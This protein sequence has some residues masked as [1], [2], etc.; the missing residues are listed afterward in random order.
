[1]NPIGI[2][3]FNP[4]PMTGAGNTT[5]LIPGRVP[6]LIDAGTGDSRHLEALAAALGDSRLCLVLVTHAH[7]DHVS[8]APAIRRRMPHV[9]F[10]KMHWAQRDTRY[11]VTWEPLIDGSIVE[12]G[13]G[14]LR[15]VH[16]PG[17]APDHLCFWDESTR[18]LLCGD[19]VVKG[20]TVVIPA[21]AGGDLEAY[22]ASLERVL[23]LNPARMLPAHGPV[24]ESPAALLREYL[25]HRREREQQVLVA[26]GAGDETVDDIVSR[27]Y[28]GL[29]QVLRPMARDSVTA[30]LR[31]LERAG[32]VRRND[33]RWSI[34]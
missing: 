11:D 19:L 15:V 5:W 31:K 30:H 10:A 24:I 3:V 4:G 28:A 22:L 27:V 29:D 16:T 17:H 9:R 8:G 6:V 25:A 2:H 14:T 7:V 20:R 13:D 32:V 1:L 34:V 23:A 21:N 18:T 26:L 12:A 33:D